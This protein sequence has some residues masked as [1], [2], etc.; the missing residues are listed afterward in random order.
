MIKTYNQARDYVASLTLRGIVPGLTSIEALCDALD[1]P[2]DKIR[3]IHIAGTNGKGSTGAFISSILQ[4]AG[5]SVGRYVSP[6]VT[7][8]REIISI[9]DEYISEEE[10]TSIMQ[11]V[12][13]A[14]KTAEEKR[15][16]PTTFEAE[17]AAA[18]LYFAEK[19]CDYVLI[20]CGMGGELDA[21]NIIKS[22]VAAVIT[23]IGMD[24]TAFLGDTIEEIARNKAGII[25][26]GTAVFSSQQ[27][28]E[29]IAVLEE[30][31][32]E[33]NAALTVSEVP[34]II[35]SD[36]R[37]TRFN[38]RD[39]KDITIPLAG[40][41]QP[42]NAATAIDLCLR[43]GIGG[44]T[45]IKGLRDTKWALRFECDSDGWIYDGAHNKAAAGEL[46]KSIKNLI[47]GKTAYIIGVF[48][49]K[50]YEAILN[51]TAFGADRIYTV[52]APGARGLDSE[53]L[54]QTAQ[55]YCKD[56]VNAGT[57]ENA[58]RLCAKDDFDNVV[59]FGS[60]S[61]LNCI[62]QEKEKIYGEM[63]KNI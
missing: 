40:A 28:E 29:V 7:E 56:V 39:L 60:L 49:D 53:I 26:E 45:I 18:F 27:S 19:K 1:N 47:K 5:Y 61:F 58:V 16:Y 20:E 14:V 13:E 8:Y 54:A 15:I 37:G 23:S 44:D 4:S 2:Q 41:Y 42:I 31:C 34:E 38:Y 55:K 36:T 30:K 59:V 10:Y 6:A 24:H 52:T 50:D 43:L 63:S 11:K 9:N 33:K 32:R 12:S 51:L 21:T 3:T 22:P 48:A 25:K 35:S 62:K 46:A 17:T 57:T